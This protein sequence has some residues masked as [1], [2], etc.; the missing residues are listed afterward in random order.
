[1]AVVQVWESVLKTGKS[2]LYR[3]DPYAFSVLT[4]SL[5]FERKPALMNKHNAIWCLRSTPYCKTSTKS[6]W[7]VRICISGSCVARKSN[8][9][10]TYLN[11]RSGLCPTIKEMGITHGRTIAIPNTH[12]MF[13]GLSAVVGTR[14][15]SPICTPEDF[16]AGRRTASS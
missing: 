4:N 13:M 15:T 2:S 10:L 11:Q 1:M 8:Q 6:L 14:V 3:S 9:P 7:L 5:L 12:S 16:N